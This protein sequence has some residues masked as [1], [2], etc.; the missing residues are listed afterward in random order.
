MKLIFR[1]VS[2]K[3][4]EHDFVQRAIP[5]GER[6]LWTRVGRQVSKFLGVPPLFLAELQASATESSLGE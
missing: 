2:L 3:I 5:L 6:A 4:Q 1:A